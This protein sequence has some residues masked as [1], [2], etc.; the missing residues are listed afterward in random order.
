MCPGL[1]DIDFLGRRIKALDGAGIFVSG[2][3]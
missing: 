1:L 2:G 3:V